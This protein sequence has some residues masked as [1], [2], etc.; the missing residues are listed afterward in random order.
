MRAAR[1]R[2]SPMRALEFARTLA[3]SLRRHRLHVAVSGEGPARRWLLRRSWRHPVHVRE[4][5]E[6]ADRP[7]LRRFLAQVP[8][9]LDDAPA[10]S[11]VRAVVRP[12][13]D[14][15][16][17]EGLVAAAATVDDPELRRR[18]AAKLVDEGAGE[19]ALVVLDAA[20]AL[21]LDGARMLEL[22]RRLDDVELLEAVLRRTTPAILEGSTRR[23]LLRLHG[24][25]LL[26][27]GKAAYHRR[28]EFA[29]LAWFDRAIAEAGPTVHSL[30][31]S[32]LTLRR[33][34]RFQDARHRAD[35]ALAVRPDWAPALVLLAE[36]H[37]Q[38]GETEAAV[39]LW[40]RVLAKD[41][42]PRFHLKRTMEGLLEV[43]EVVLTLE[44]ADRLALEAPDDPEAIGIRAVALLRL[45]RTEE[46][47]STVK[48]LADRDDPLAIQEHAYALLLLGRTEQA[49]ER[50]RQLPA[51]DW[52]PSIT[53]RLLHELR[54]GGHLDA[55][56]AVARSAADGTAHADLAD[57]AAVLEGELSVLDGSWSPPRPRGPRHRSG[58]TGRVL[59]VV[60]RSV[61]YAS[62]GYAVRTQYTVRAQRAAGIDAQVATQLGFPWDDVD[63]PAAFE[64]VDGVPHHRLPWPGDGRRPRHLGEQLAWNIEAL[65]AL[66]ERLEPAVLHAASDF[67]NAILALEVG[68]RFSLPVVYEMRGFWEETWLAKRDD[69]AMLSA[70]YRLRR[71]REDDAA[72][73]ADHVITLAPTMRDALIE[74][75]LPAERISLAPNAVDPAAFPLAPRDLDLLAELGIPSAVPVVG[76]ISSF[77]AYEGIPILLEAV[78]RL[79]DEGRELRCVLVGDGEALPML[80]RRVRELDL[81]GIV[82]LTGRVEHRRIR[83][84]YSILDVFVL[85]RTNARVCRLVSPLKPYEAMA[86]ERAVL[87]SGTPVLQ[88][89]VEDGVTGV[90]FAPEDPADLAREMGALL[91][92][93]DRRTALGRQARAQV[94]AEHTWERNAERYS[95]VYRA[96]GVL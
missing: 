66:V 93:P 4:L 36:L 28:D 39:A 10:T 21:Q 79:R 60:G 53:R 63:E 57:L 77:S 95:E 65:A 35:E 62:S 27:L 41:A 76:Y 61:P 46:A 3:R 59:H 44:A 92:D 30:T 83:A 89:V 74:R 1:G 82:L 34:G 45:G 75:G 40:E 94:L 24:E 70:V 29:A 51:G 12:P 13:E 86:A 37:E 73:R 67:R 22:V 68:E 31:W 20:P 17:L 88:T 81:E 64:E 85:P 8:T 84:Y 15:A 58:V 55:A 42:V 91:D 32:G 33:L 47:M 6:M 2:R 18:A 52:N 80:R 5:V 7:Q 38:R 72:R 25:A 23:S 69:S 56:A 96:L 19:P 26:G 87:I 54:R 90:T 16:G 71:E 78:A 14:A 48:L 49:L 50:F 43:G 11:L 9:G